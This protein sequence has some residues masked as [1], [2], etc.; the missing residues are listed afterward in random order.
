MNV[1]YPYITVTKGMSGWFAVMIVDTDGLP[2]PECTGIGRYAL[3]SKAIAE[4]RFWAELDGIPFDMP[5]I[6]ESAARQDVVQQMR[7]IIPDLQ[8]IHIED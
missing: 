4:G 7:E 2:E 5:S 8:V 3:Q 6:D 1:E